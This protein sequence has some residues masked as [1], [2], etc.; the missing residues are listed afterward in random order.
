M[1]CCLLDTLADV[2]T[3][4]IGIL[5]SPGGL[6]LGGTAKKAGNIVDT[7]VYALF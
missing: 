1:I 6:F 4:R 2:K 5:S 3:R 7:L